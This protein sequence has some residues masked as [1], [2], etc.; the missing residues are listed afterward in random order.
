MKL[1]K[2][3]DWKSLSRKDLEREYNPSS[4]IGGDYR[5]YIR[6]Y[7]TRSQLSK[8][9]LN[10]IECEYG[11][12]STNTIDLFIPKSASPNTPCPLMVF[13]H[14]GYWQE[15]SKHESQFSA[16]D[17]VKNDI[18]FATI[19]YTLCPEASIEEIINECQA[20]INWLQGS[21]QNYNYDPKKIYISG[22]SA[23][24]HLAAM[25]SL[26]SCNDNDH[27]ISNLAGIVLIS[28]IYDLEPLIST[29]INNSI[30]MD[31]ASAMLASPLFKDLNGFPNTI[32]T[33]GEYETTEF[34]EQSMIFSEALI[35]NGINVQTLEIRNRNHFD[36]ILDL[37]KDD[38]DLGK[39]VIKMIKDGSN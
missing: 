17:F 1:H 35:K 38:K 19:D 16:V 33:W 34:K 29:T 31:K 28:G 3:T 25:C 26:K 12:K 30:G 13:I 11:P 2:R 23:G 20:A 24:A 6:Q 15:L 39:K 8:N 4:I 7:I 22:S 32:I 10:L 5:P 21:F 36:I 18:A 27:S 14:G 9:E 37:G